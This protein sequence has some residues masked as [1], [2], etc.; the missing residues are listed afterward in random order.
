MIPNAP[1]L[2]EQI[3]RYRVERLVGRGA[4]GVIYR[5]HDP[6]IDR[7]VAIKLVRTDLLE[8]MDRADILARF[9]REAQAAGRCVHPNIVAVHD[10]ATHEGNPFFVMEFV[11]GV[12]LDRVIADGPSFSPSAAVDVL[13]QVFAAL[14]CAHG[15]GIVH[16]DIKPANVLLLP[17]GRV[18]VADFGISRLSG[19]E[20]T[21]SGAMVG[22]P[23]YMSPEQCRGDTIDLRSDLFSAGV[24][25]YE[26]LA[27]E[28]PFPG[29][30]FAEITYRLLNQVPADLTVRRPDA[31][32]GLSSVLQR[33][34]AKDPRER[35]A[36]AAEMAE[37]LRAA[38]RWPAA[39]PADS[40]RTEL[41]RPRPPAATGRA[42][43]T[44]FGESALSDIERK[45][46]RHVGPIAH[47][48]V[49]SALRRAGSIEDLCG[50]LV[51]SIEPAD[52]R[53]QFMREVLGGATMEGGR[54]QVDRTASPEPARTQI[55]A[56]EI[57]RAE[58]AL[59]HF[60]GPMAR[61]L[62]R[63]AAEKSG[64]AAELW[65]QLATHIDS[66]ADRDVFLRSD[67]DRPK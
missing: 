58:R 10:F 46:A 63:R 51:Q 56:E 22:T 34:L 64:S 5:A 67:P 36:S 57:E 59:R 39:S 14:G 8:G 2:P 66:A 6:V 37:T 45:L 19:S 62:V 24:V 40:D 65:R 35:F 47:Y 30:N 16:R 20:L 55:P 18:K 4:M 53:A 42:T 23:S 33:A 54:T 38:L 61:I 28:R 21:Q 25:L 60:V 48:L 17:D 49:Q 15:L 1:A 31:P 44:G 32:P 13:L 43:T 27:G 9:Q 50:S 11:E 29:R 3:G 26:L 41:L 7:P 52:A 12:S